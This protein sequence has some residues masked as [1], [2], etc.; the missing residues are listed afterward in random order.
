MGRA[1][2]ET[3]FH[4][5]EGRNTMK[6]AML[7]LGTIGLAGAVSLGVLSIQGAAAADDNDAF[8]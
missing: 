8:V 6:K 4:P 5:R 1:P 2:T 7:G 3:G